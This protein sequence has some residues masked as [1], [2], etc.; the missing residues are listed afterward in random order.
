MTMKGFV[1]RLVTDVRWV[2]AFVITWSTLF[3]GFYLPL[4]DRIDQMDVPLQIHG[5]DFPFPCR[6]IDWVVC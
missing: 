1:H 4:D 6:R 5:E 2:A 3:L